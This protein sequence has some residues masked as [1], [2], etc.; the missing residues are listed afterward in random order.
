MTTIL[1]LCGSTR[2]TSLNQMLLDVAAAGAV[3]AGAAVTAV[4]LADFHLPLFDA[5]L[6]RQQGLPAPAK[7][8]QALIRSHDGLLIA[9]PEYNG[10]YTAVLKNAL[11]WASRPREDGSMGM[12][13]FAGKLAAVISASPGPLGGMR[14]QIALKIVLDKLGVMVIPQSFALGAAHQAFDAERKLKD[15]Q[16]ADAVAAV[17]VSLV[18]ALGAR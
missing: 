6:E 16:A 1:A 11:D 14:S 12:A 15:R 5:D 18:R 7:D 17:G 9:S 13:T 8:L 10:G 2:A 3:G 4:A